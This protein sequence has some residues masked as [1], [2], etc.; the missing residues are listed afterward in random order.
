VVITI[1][2]AHLAGRRLYRSLNLAA[3]VFA[4]ALPAS[5]V[6]DAGRPTVALAA[7]AAVQAAGLTPGQIESA[8]SLP[9]IGAKGQRIAIVGA[10]DDPGVQADLAAYTKRFSLPSCTL[11]NGCFHELNQAGAASPLP[12]PDLSGGT[13]DTESSAGSELAR[14]TCQSCSILLVEANSPSKSDLSA[15]VATA[16]KAGAT[17]TVTTFQLTE[18][19]SDL[20]YGA[21]YSHPGT[22]VVS[23]TGDV[24]YAGEAYFPS[25]LASVL[26]VGGTS[27]ELTASGGYKRESAWSSS[28]SGCALY[29]EAPLWQAAFARSLGCRS[30]RAVPDLAAVSDPGAL[31][32]IADAGVSGGPWYQEMGTSVSAPIIAGMIGLAGS[33][34][35]REASM[36]YAHARSD[37]G[38]FHDVAS[39]SENGCAAG[40]P[41]CSARPGPDGATGLGTPDGLAAFLP[42]GGS[43]DLRRP[44]VTITA[45]H[46][47]LKADRS[48]SVRLGLQNGN[49][50]ALHGTVMLSGRIR[51]G[52]RLRVTSFSTGARFTIPPLASSTARIVVS[53]SRRRLLRTLGAIQVTVV[54]RI[55]GPTGLAALLS[56]SVRLKAP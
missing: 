38:A 47:A 22:T 35:S 33:V 43:L 5:A 30:T 3:L 6:A 4:L 48:W 54:L 39:G 15:A 9:K 51:I 21:D 1:G 29:G 11:A 2:F 10:Y 37:P 13:F 19:P 25:S 34:G 12:G 45:P 16:A 53:G 7:S 46:G 20:G 18:D 52:R 44:E 41:I 24:G 36:L 55:A 31:V 56:R 17:V 8:Y 40:N 50:F 28:T 49:P 32:R 42:S 27:L 26:A 14:A 23:A